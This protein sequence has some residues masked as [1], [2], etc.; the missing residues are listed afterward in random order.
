MHHVLDRPF[1]RHTRPVVAVALLV[2]GAVLA[3]PSPAASAPSG[4]APVV[5]PP[6]AVSPV[7]V[8]PVLTSD[9]TGGE[10]PSVSGDG[11]WV[12]VQGEIEG[13]STVFRTDRVTGTTVELT[14]VLDGVR[15]GDSV[16]PVV[17]GDG[18]VVVVH[19][20]MPLDL[21]RDDDL[22][23]RWDVYRLVVPECGGTPGSWE[24]VSTD[25]L[26]G[27]ARDDVFVDW[28]ATVSG[29][30]AIVAFTH[31][32]PGLR[33]GVATITVVDLTVAHG[34]PRRYQPVAGMP[35]EAPDTVYRYRGPHQPAL[36][37]NGR[38]LAFVSDTTADDPLPGW[39]EGREPGG[40]ATTQV[41]VWDR[42]NDDAFTRVQLL[43]ARDGA[44]SRVGATSP[45]LSENGRIV[46]FVSADQTLVPAEY[47]RCDSQCPTQIYRF[48]RDPDGNGRFDE[49]TR[50]RQLTLVSA[51][52]DGGNIGGLIAGDASSRAP[53]VNI[54]GSQV[55][56]VTRATNLVATR[57]PAGGDATE[58]DV[59]IAEIPLGS[60]RRVTHEATG[61]AVPG[62][63]DRPALSDTGRVVVF[64][65]LVAGLMAGDVAVTGRHVV[66]VSSQPQVSLAALDFGT[67]LVGWESEELYVS[68]L[69]EGPGAFAPATV[70]S[71]LANFKITDGGTCRRGLVVPAGGTCT[72]YVVFNPTAA[73]TFLGTIDVLEDTFEGVDARATVAGVGGEPVLQANPPGLD[74]ETA[75]VGLSGN[76]RSIDIRNISF[77]P[78]SISTIRIVGA[79]PD[80]FEVV[81]QSCTNRALN[82][83]ATCTVEIG[84]DPTAG[85]RR[86]AT[87]QALT[88]TGGYTAAI[89][90]GIG[91][92]RPSIGVG[93]DSV[94]AGALLPIG[95][96]GFPGD[97][98]VTVTFADSS[99]PVAVLRTNAD[100]G[101]LA[102]VPIARRE[103][104]GSRMLVATGPQGTSAVVPIEVIRRSAATRGVPGYGMG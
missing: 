101:L 85:G 49:P 56:F 17:S 40:P 75:E 6:V 11:R 52:S 41:Y 93:T 69:N 18:C 51:V 14:P 64:D 83:N 21:F 78:T 37:A 19:T 1:R 92:Y 10:R 87:V 71:S 50:L 36:S 42:V 59:L 30:G 72:V 74:L 60:M 2:T 48:D 34:D 25:E 27:T 65:S 16:R 13:R 39:G 73:T 102:Q 54:D 26:T 96:N 76:R 31:P 94:R 88:P 58:G 29:S 45:A 68:V 82:P 5:A 77:A 99:R 91:E 100:G 8:P 7:A 15:P 4:A 62:A 33:D 67:V 90:A 53:A 70:R 89:V 98:E 79:H 9:L 44:P 84:F 63:H 20:E 95:L 86:M 35:G 57:V 23:D 3:V 22:G 38:H 81:T 32:A 80:D 46:V 24:L 28:P 66:A 43:S 97:A 61:R 104:G 47:P 55:A 12:V 103:R